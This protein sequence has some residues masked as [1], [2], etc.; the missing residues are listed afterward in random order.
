MEGSRM[1]RSDFRTVVEGPRPA[2][3]WLM[4]LVAS[5]AL[6]ITEQLPIWLIGIQCLAF[7]IGLATRRDPPAFRTNAVWLNVFM[8]GI[9]TITI[10]SALAGNPA[11]VSLAWFTALAQAL[12]LLDARPRKS[13]FVLV[14]V[15]LFQI[16]LA[17]TLTD[18]ILFPPLLV[19][20]VV[21]VTWTLL[22]HTLSMEATEAGDPGAASAV[23]ASD[24]RRMTFL[25]TGLCLALAILLFMLFPRIETRGFHPGAGR[26]F[27][28]SG[29]STRV[30]L[31]D[32]G[33]IR[34]DP[35]IVLRVESP[36]GRLP[37]PEKAYWRGLAFDAFDG[38]DWSISAS[39]HRAA[40]RALS[41]VGRFGVEL[42]PD[43]GSPLTIQRIIREPVASNVLF[44]PAR[45]RRIQGP[46]QALERDRNGGLYLPGPGNERIRYTLWSDIGERDPDR[47]R[48]ER[49][50]PPLEPGP[51]GERP[52]LRYL[53]LPAVDPRVRSLADEITRGATNDYD[54]AWRIQQALRRRGRYSDTPP[55][56][57]DAEST[58]IDAFLLGELE[59]H[60]EYF[61]SAMVTLARLEGL[62]SRLVNGFAGGVANELGGFI[63]VTRA[64][65]HAWVEVHFEHSGWIRFDPTP[66]DRRLRSARPLSLFA[67]LAQ[68]GSAVELWWFQRVVDFDSVDQIGVL[69]R[70]WRSWTR[71]R[72]P[73][74]D[75]PEPGDRRAWP[76]G[77]D[78]RGW[79]DPGW[80]LAALF[81]LGIGLSGWR[82]F[83][84]VADTRVP[85]GYRAAL[86]ILAR[87]G[88]VRP[89]TA[90]AR[91]FAASVRARV[92]AAGASAFAE[93]TDAYLAS[94]FGAR[95]DPDLR[96]R[97]EALENAV[98]GMRLGNQTDIG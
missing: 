71:D 46:F 81:L 95:P 94:R 97:L 55:R 38:R 36:D 56:L 82:R 25:A 93:I 30:S 31:G 11:T 66:P 39:E 22:V 73:S 98:D 83:R 52:A 14:A 49:A 76:F 7:A 90:T 79:P 85:P 3:A 50:R 8:L 26:G 72:H 60:C 41:G 19:I 77:S 88:L 57:D 63:E 6:W 74:S 9:T 15:A 86:R 12:Q 20:F 23:L 40:R 5:A 32:V 33:R 10:R 67:R 75:G 28:L 34:Q 89:A 47:L 37:D 35:S 45:T 18:S 92:P 91:D 70:L 27:A 21:S 17:S 64:D 29:F 16:V 24:L 44:V 51:G 2:S 96:D 84:S 68:I 42:L 87:R 1:T 53:A 13:E 80:I 54:R 62:P 43:A 59:G 58:P 78:S 61:A 48:G 4:A 69:R 65:A